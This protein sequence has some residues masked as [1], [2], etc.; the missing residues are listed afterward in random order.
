MKES[1]IRKSI[2]QHVLDYE[3]PSRTNEF[4]RAILAILT[5]RTPGD[6]SEFHPWLTVSA[7]KYNSTG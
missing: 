1:T 2:E 5:D 7:G 6:V 4:P 3:V